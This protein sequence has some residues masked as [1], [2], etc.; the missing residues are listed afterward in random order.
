[1]SKIRLRQVR[2]AI[3]RT[4]DQHQTLRGLRLGRPGKV[5]VLED[6]PSVRGMVRKV[7]HLVQEEAEDGSVVAG[8]ALAAARP[9]EGAAS[10]A[11]SA[12]SGAAKKG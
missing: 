8:P 9:R 10:G 4:Q 1:M 7:Q 12:S 11:A 3:G 6:T 5:S 2:S